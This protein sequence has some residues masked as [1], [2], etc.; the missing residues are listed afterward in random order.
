MPKLAK[1]LSALAVKNIQHSGR[2]KDV[3]ERYAVGG[4]SGLLLQVTPNNAKSW[5]LRTTVAGNRQ[6]MGFGS[7]PEVSLKDARERAA[8][9]KQQVRD[10]V[11]P[12]VDRKVKKATLEAERLRGRTFGQVVEE[13][14]NVKMEG[15]RK[16][17]SSQWRSNRW[18][19]AESLKSAL[20]SETRH[21]NKKYG[22]QTVEKNCTRFLMCSNHHDALPFDNGDRRIIVVENPTEKRTKEYFDMLYRRQF[23][24]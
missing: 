7:Y 17:T 20:T 12:I 21:I 6:L 13:Y 10:G 15:E 19:K 16:K 18:A 3:P 9:A 14:L 8:A 11:D 2:R 22:L 23:Q 5:L 1:E 24:G 4:V